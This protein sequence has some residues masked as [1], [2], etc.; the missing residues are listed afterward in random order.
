M[1]CKRNHLAS[2]LHQGIIPVFSVTLTPI[3]IRLS[4]AAAS[5]LILRPKVPAIS[6]PRF[7]SEEGEG[8]RM[9]GRF[10]D[11][12]VT[13][14]E[15]IVPLFGSPRFILSFFSYKMPFFRSIFP[16][17]IKRCLCSVAFPAGHTIQKNLAL[18][19]HGWYRDGIKIVGGRCF[20]TAVGC[21]FR[22][23]RHFATPQLSS[24]ATAPHALRLAFVFERV[25]SRLFL[26]R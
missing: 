3:I 23:E 25:S 12:G 9:V 2:R 15:A 4:A 1:L 11:M 22:Q 13:C 21:S 10:T 6:W 19:E 14:H 5:F 26:G 18:W 8:G 17:R 7:G 16:G 24:K 20:C